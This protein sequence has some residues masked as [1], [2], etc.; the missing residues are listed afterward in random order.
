MT[1]TRDT[2]KAFFYLR[3][4]YLT[5]FAMVVGMIN[6]LTATYFLAIEKIPFLQTIFPTFESY[7]IVVII[8]GIP[9]VVIVGWI[10]LKKIGTYAAEMNVS[11]EA[12]PYNY[13]FLPGWTI[14]VFGPAYHELV[15]V[16]SKKIKEEKITE[17]DLISLKKLEDQLRHLIE[18]GYVGNPPKGAF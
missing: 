12:N 5:Y 13:K 2:F 6:I 11:V 18:G 4:G 8:I 1:K 3:I 10:H 14:E 7:V 16:Y 9:T 15:K 17:Q